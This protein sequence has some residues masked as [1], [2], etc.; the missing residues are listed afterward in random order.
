MKILIIGSEGFIGSHAR[1][2][3]EKIGCK[4]Y[5]ADV[6]NIDRPNYKK[7]QTKEE[8]FSQLF[9]DSS[10]DVCINASGSANVGFS[11]EQP[12]LDFELNV[13][14]VQKI[15]VAARNYAPECKLINFSSAAIYGNPE[16]LPIAESHN[17][18]PLSPYGFH[19]LQSELLMSEYHKFFG[20]HTCSLRVFSA[21]GPRLKKQLFW[22]LYQKSLKT[23]QPELFG[24]GKESRDFI[25]IDDL[26]QIIELIINQSKF[27]G[28]V[29]N[30][31]NGEEISIQTAAYIFYKKLNSA[32]HPHFNNQVKQGDPLNWRADI[33]KIKNLG[34]KQSVSFEE[35]IERYVSWLDSRTN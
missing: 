17:P 26:I 24:S 25:F 13:L 4:V 31:A 18:N 9:K 5:S 2:Y 12:Q 7:L 15:L 29:F 16:S 28:S 32:I 8:N 34:Y 14:N 1:I 33:E 30:V 22:E 6:L 10:P 23:D 11:F 27:E 3:F 20:L 21:F 35:G 19:K